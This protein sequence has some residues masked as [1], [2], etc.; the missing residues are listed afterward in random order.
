MHQVFITQKIKKL[1][2]AQ[3][4]LLT[5]QT[6]PFCTYILYDFERKLK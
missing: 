5:V 3:L 4:V 2:E 1:K 6:S